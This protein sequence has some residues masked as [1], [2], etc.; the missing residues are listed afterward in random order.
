[1]KKIV[2]ALFLS[3][4]ALLINVSAQKRAAKS[5]CYDARTQLEMNECADKQFQ[6]ADAELNRV[7]KQLVSKAENDP[8]LKTAEVSWLKYRDDNCAYEASMYE[9]GSMQPMVYSFCLERMTKARTAE[10]GVQLKEF[11]K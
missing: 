7:Y 2:P 5:P 3:C 9:G 1:M 11:D 4:A 8:K 6:A 10:L